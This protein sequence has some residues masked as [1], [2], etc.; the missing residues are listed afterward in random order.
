MGER[1]T[2]LDPTL[3]SDGRGL[4]VKTESGR[5]AG[6]H[7]DLAKGNRAGP[8][9]FDRCLL[10]GEAGGEVLGRP[11]AGTSVCELLRLKEAIGQAGLSLERPLDPTDLD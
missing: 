7:L 1:D 8:K 3:A 2:Q 10:G 6:D 4:A 5:L 11:A 9:S